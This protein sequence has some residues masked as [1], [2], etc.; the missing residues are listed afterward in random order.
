MYKDPG[1]ITTIKHE[2]KIYSS[3]GDGKAG[4]IST[5]DIARAA[6]RVLTDEK[7]HNKAYFLTGSELLSVDDVRPHTRL[8]FPPT[9]PPPPSPS[10]VLPP[11]M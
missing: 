11:I 1:Y 8:P 2:S 7:P 6:L 9:R 4:F 5:A 3:F 10:P